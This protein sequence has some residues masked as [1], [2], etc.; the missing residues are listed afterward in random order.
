M[1]NSEKVKKL[2]AEGVLPVV[3]SIGEQKNKDTNIEILRAP[4]FEPHKITLSDFHNANRSK[5]TVMK[6]FLMN[7][8][9]MQNAVSIARASQSNER[10]VTIIGMVYSISKLPKGTLRLEVED[11]S[12]KITVIIS[13]KKQELLKKAQFITEDEVVGFIGGCSKNTFFA[14]EIIWPDIPQ[15]QIPKA[16]D[17]VN[18]LFLSDIHVGSNMFLEK[19]FEEFIQWLNSKDAQNVKYIL[20]AGDVVDGVGVY[21]Q[22][23]KELHV[24]DIYE[25]YKILINYLKQIPKDKQIIICPGTHDGVRL[26][27]PK[28][29]ITKSLAPE[30][31][32][33]ENIHLVT[34]PCFVRLH[35]VG[36]F[37]GISILMYHGDSF[38]FYIN[39]VEALRLSGGYDK[40]S[41]VHKF[42]LQRRSLSPTYGGQEHLP[43]N[44]DA[45]TIYQVP[46]VMHTGHIH[47]SDIGS[48]KGVMLICSSCFQSRTSFQEKLGHHPDPGKIILLNLKDLKIKVIDF[49]KKN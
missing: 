37:P 46:D 38:D 7:R 48:Y 32:E 29:K 18:V 21:P 43:M 28:P 16:K 34:N 41:E 10:N 2:L 40:G 15:K 44:E 42:F 26:E 47:K 5:F 1:E 20:L 24:L 19:E 11:F 45:L 8:S 39:H 3:E 9:E 22:Q 33:I 49:M 17:D 35:R 30:L 13:T 12:S 25:Q 6:N 23:N 31:Y 14:D 36:D 4:H 27:D